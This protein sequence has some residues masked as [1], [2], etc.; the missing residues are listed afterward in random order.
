MITV[1]SI[2]DVNLSVVVLIA[3]SA[4]LNGRKVVEDAFCVVL[5]YDPP[6]LRFV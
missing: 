4:E 3:I 6:Y 5:L 2:V 1:F